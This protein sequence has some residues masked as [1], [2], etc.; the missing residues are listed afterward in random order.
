MSDNDF[1]AAPGSGWP[2]R[3]CAAAGALAP[4][5]LGAAVLALGGGTWW[6]AR[7]SYL[8]RFGSLDGG[9]ATDA[10]AAWGQFGDFMGGFVNPLLTLLTLL[11]LIATVA[12]QWRQLQTSRAE[13]EATRDELKKTVRAQ[14]DAAAALRE[15]LEIAEHTARTHQEAA[16]YQLATAQAMN[17]QAGYARLTSRVQ[18]LSALLTAV[19]HSSM[20]MDGD[21]RTRHV[22]AIGNELRALVDALREDGPVAL[23][24]ADR[25]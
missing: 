3:L 18:A 5:G 20:P 19:S 6:W 22:Q 23:D 9:A 16:Q 17:E 2:A 13:L 11:A 1:S 12:L 14:Q 7:A 15:Q 24:P 4:W 8:Q 25:H 21:Q 10:R